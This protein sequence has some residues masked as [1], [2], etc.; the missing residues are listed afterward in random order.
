M[1]IGFEPV[2]FVGIVEKVDELAVGRCKVR[3]FGFHGPRPLQQ[4]NGQFTDPTSPTATDGITRRGGTERVEPGIE[5]DDLPWASIV[6]SAG[7]QGII[8]EG[9]WVFGCFMDGRDA[10]HPLIMGIIPGMNLGLPAESAGG[11][12]YSHPGHAAANF[13]DSSMHPAMTGEGGRGNA[14]AML[15]SRSEFQTAGRQG[16]TF[17]QPY[18]HAAHDTMT[19]VMSSE[20]KLNAFITNNNDIVMQ[21]GNAQV[22]IDSSGNVTIFAPSSNIEFV[23]GGIKQATEGAIGISAGSK[24]TV[25][26]NEGGVQFDTNGDFEVNCSSFKVNARDR[27]WV[28]AGAGLDLRGAKVHV[29]ARTD[30]VDIWAK[31]KTRLY[32]G[33]VTTIEV[34]GFEGM[35]ITS[36]RVNWFNYFDFKL[37]SLA[38][39]NINSPGL[40]DLKGSITNVTGYGYAGLKSTGVTD[41]FGPVVNMDVFVN[42]GTGAST[43][44][45]PP[46]PLDVALH[47]GMPLGPILSDHFATTPKLPPMDGSNIKMSVTDLPASVPTLPAPSSGMVD[48]VDVNATTNHSIGAGSLSAS[49]LISNLEDIL[50]FKF[51]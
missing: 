47:I 4:I 51:L 29:N 9:E 48:D 8:G 36:K 7:A 32:S 3:A 45:L 38:A 21:S 20:N 41:V 15:A 18:V 27:A 2:W 28:Q 19:R 39:V 34:G 43:P 49:G 13:G 24:Y 30:S 10:Q 22:Q 35:Y 11:N 37:T 25:H 5:T 31:E 23:G 14:M 26:V 46:T 42:M 50:N 33:G 12:G 17:A 6:Q 16:M 40:V 44:P 1:N